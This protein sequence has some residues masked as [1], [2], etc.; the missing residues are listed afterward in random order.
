MA[1]YPNNQ[2]RG[3]VC[4]YFKENYTFYKLNLFTEY[5]LQ[6]ERQIWDYKPADANS[7]KKSLNQVNWD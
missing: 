1:D 5:P 4:L 3:G 6:Y 2:K 7:V